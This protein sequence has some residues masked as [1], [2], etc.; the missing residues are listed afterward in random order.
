MI[1]FQKVKFLKRIFEFCDYSNSNVKC[2]RSK[3][4]VDF[5]WGLPIPRQKVVWDS[6]NNVAKDGS[7]SI[8]DWVS[9]KRNFQ[10]FD[11]AW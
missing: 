8:P 4:E 9:R 11:P 5:V 2:G 3:L 1:L 10:V 6:M 7:C